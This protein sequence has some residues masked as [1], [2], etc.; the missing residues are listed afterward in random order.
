MLRNQAGV[1]PT[2]RYQP[3]IGK[4]G[5][6]D[7]NSNPRLTDAALISLTRG[8]SIYRLASYFRCAAWDA[9]WRNGWPTPEVDGGQDGEQ[10][11]DFNVQNVQNVKDAVDITPMPSSLRA[12]I[13]GAGK[14][15]Q[16]PQTWAIFLLYVVRLAAVGGGLY[17][18]TMLQGEATLIRDYGVTFDAMERDVLGYAYNG[19]A[20]LQTSYLLTS[21]VSF[22]EVCIGMIFVW[23]GVSG[24]SGMRGSVPMEVRNWFAASPELEFM[25]FGVRQIGFF[26]G[27]LVF[28]IGVYATREQLFQQDAYNLDPSY[29]CLDSTTLNPD[30]S[31]TLHAFDQDGRF[32]WPGMFRFYRERMKNTRVSQFYINFISMPNHASPLK[33]QL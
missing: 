21:L 5:A 14:C 25:P 4:N 13:L 30:G 12:Q 22:V 9:D 15:W 7:D 11:G 23:G 32:G 8:G 29:T 6:F 20:W 16:R 18:A 33:S 27:D 28:C 2:Q 19:W 1:D 24:V 17:A 3:K 26:L 10:E 31:P